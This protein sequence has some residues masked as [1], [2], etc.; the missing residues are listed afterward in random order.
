MKKYEILYIDPPWSYNFNRYPKNGGISYPVMTQKDLCSLPIDEI[1]EKNAIMF[2]WGTW[3]KL[4]QALEFIKSTGFIYKTN[5]FVWNKKNKDGSIRMG[6]G[7]WTRSSTEFCLL[8]TKGSPKRISN[9]VMQDISAPILG[10][11]AKPLITRNKII[12]LVGNLPAIEIFARS[13]DPNFDTIGNDI[14]GLD[15]N[16]ELQQIIDGT[17]KQS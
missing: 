11:S 15:I 3:P 1:S 7:H 9:I 8:A 10:H 13:R 4:E 16:V 6:L 17:W 14:S 2:C 12:E 5:A